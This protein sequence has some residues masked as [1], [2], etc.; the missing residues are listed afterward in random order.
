VEA[1]GRDEAA[2][3]GGTARN[4]QTTEVP[5]VA[6]MLAGI[7]DDRNVMGLT[8][9][10]DVATETIYFWSSPLDGLRTRIEV[11]FGPWVRE[12]TPMRL[13]KRDNF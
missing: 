4:E 7:F 11:A 8:D 1:P 2:T 10:S 13:T 9:G 6:R 3:A 12:V 5:I